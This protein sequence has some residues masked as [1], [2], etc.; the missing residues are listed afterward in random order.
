MNWYKFL[1]VSP[2]IGLTEVLSINNN[3]NTNMIKKKLQAICILCLIL[4]KKS[5]TI[6]DLIM[7]DMLAIFI[8]NALFIL[9]LN[10]QI[11]RQ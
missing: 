7:V 9:D 5:L 1:G 3:N 4:A 8:K 2:T 6:P 10:L 11:D